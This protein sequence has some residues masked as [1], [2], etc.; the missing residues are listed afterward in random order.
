MKQQK[1]NKP[2][3]FILFVQEWRKSRS[4]N[5]QWD[6]CIH[7][8]GPAWKN[9]TLEDRQ[10]YINKALQLR[11][12]TT[13]N[14]IYTAEERIDIGP[15]QK[16]RSMQQQIEELVRDSVERKELKT[17]NY[18][19]VTVNYF[20]KDIYTPAELASAEFSLQEGVQNVYH[21]LINPGSAVYGSLSETQEH[22]NATHQLPV[23]PNALGNEDIEGVYANLL[24]FVRTGLVF[25]LQ[26]HLQIVNNALKFLRGGVA[27]QL[28]VYPIEYLFYFLKKVTSQESMHI[29]D[30]QFQLDRHELLPNISCEFHE[31]RGLI[32]HCAKSLVTRW[33]FKF[34]ENLCLDLDITMRPNR[35]IPGNL[36]ICKK[37]KEEE[38]NYPPIKVEPIINEH[39]FNPDVLDALNSLDWDNIFEDDDCLDSDSSSN[40]EPEIAT[41]CYKTMQAE[42][43]TEDGEI[44]SDI[45]FID[46]VPA[47]P[48]SVCIAEETLFSRQSEPQDNKNNY[49]KNYESH[50]HTAINNHMITLENPLKNIESAKNVYQKRSIS[51][52]RISTR[53]SVEFHRGKCISPKRRNESESS[54]NRHSKRIGFPSLIRRNRW[55]SRSRSRSRVAS[56]HRKCLSP[57]RRDESDSSQNRYRTRICSPRSNRENC[58]RSKSRSRGCVGSNHKKCLPPKRRDESDSSQNRHRKRICSPRSNREN[59]S[60]S[61]SRSRSGNNQGGHRQSS[62][63]N[64]N[65]SPNRFGVNKV[66]HDGSVSPKSRRRDYIRLG[67]IPSYSPSRRTRERVSHVNPSSPKRHSPHQYFRSSSRLCE[68]KS[69][70]PEISYRRN[71]KY[72]T[73]RHYSRENSTTDNIIETTDKHTSTPPSITLPNDTLR[74]SCSQ[75]VESQESI[76]TII[77]TGSGK[78]VEET[79]HQRPVSIP[80]LIGRATHHYEP[81]NTYKYG[82]PPRTYYDENGQHE[83][84]LLPH[85][86]RHRLGMA[87]SNYISPYD[88]RCRIQE[89]QFFLP[90]S[91]TVG[92]SQEQFLDY[93]NNRPTW[94]SFQLSQWHNGY[95]NFV[96]NP[97]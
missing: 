43:S 45:E 25:T 24:D 65:I 83:P 30:V 90:Q 70:S 89:R 75:L 40:E 29:R 46:I 15:E 5:L 37:E 3:A 53:K 61:K 56:R 7:L 82:T 79:S 38:S 81:I 88:L 69:N 57:K 27:S 93:G 28:K 59:R 32:N 19:F 64:R 71:G 76:S 74:K 49:E 39:Q 9:M 68:Q 17:H 66:S 97:Y 87:R 41:D 80:T 58:W 2:S 67:R 12:I 63:K 51:P 86:L 14:E 72:V 94:V 44:S 96:P 60:R 77:T 95:D 84:L 33:A 8:A 62:S 36:I 55:R 21:T 11:T 54:E 50:K 10:P 22:A 13:G 52:K 16:L 78:R 47:P 23:P 42:D 4:T 91:E 35:H 85:D 20:A 6:I 18:Y 48:T 92:Y 1:D 34:A 31:Q 26:D 73:K